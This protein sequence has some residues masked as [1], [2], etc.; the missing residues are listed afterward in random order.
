[1]IEPLHA[2]Q[3]ESETWEEEPLHAQQEES[4]KW[5]EEQGDLNKLENPTTQSTF[6]T[7]FQ[8]NESNDMWKIIRSM[9]KK[10]LV[11]FLGLC[12]IRLLDLN[13]TLIGL[14]IA[15][16]L[17]HD[18]CVEWNATGDMWKVLVG[19]VSNALIAFLGCPALVYAHSFVFVRFDANRRES[20]FCILMS[21]ISSIFL[22]YLMDREQK[23]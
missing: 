23:Y 13:D 17:I 12:A 1:M 9:V 7:Y 22:I 6:G 19:I 18:G 21:C 16:V 10:V 2:Q 14:W 8:L 5:R 20:S 15:S 3:E 4:I 11:M